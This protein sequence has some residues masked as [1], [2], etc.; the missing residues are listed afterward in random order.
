MR[1]RRVLDIGVGQRALGPVPPF[2][3]LIRPARTKRCVKQGLCTD[4]L[5]RSDDGDVN[6]RP[7]ELCLRKQDGRGQPGSANIGCGQIAHGSRSCLL[8]SLLSG[9]VREQIGKTDNLRVF[10]ALWMRFI[11][12]VGGV[13]RGHKSGAGVSGKVC[14]DEAAS[15]FGTL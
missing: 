13:S 9:V 11:G 1:E 4:I 3:P 10:V 6:G 8:I 15:V 12:L 5:F 7:R 2:D 14:C